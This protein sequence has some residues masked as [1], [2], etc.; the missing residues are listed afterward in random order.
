[1]PFYTSGQIFGLAN[2][3]RGAA[4]YEI[5]SGNLGTAVASNDAI[6]TSHVLILAFIVAGNVLYFYRKYKGKKE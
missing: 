1:M 4:E 3:L 5:L 6:S 2:G